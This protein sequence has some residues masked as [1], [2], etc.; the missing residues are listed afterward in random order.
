MPIS[1]TPDGKVITRGGLPSCT[2]CGCPE[3]TAVCVATGFDFDPPVS[4]SLFLGSISSGSFTDSGI[5]LSWDGT[6]WNI[7]GVG[8]GGNVTRCDPTGYYWYG[9]PNLEPSAYWIVGGFDA[10]GTLPVDPPP[11]P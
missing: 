3:Q 5:V 8:Y 11:Y 6:E 10:C 7:D 1:V 2:C 9:N 4:Q